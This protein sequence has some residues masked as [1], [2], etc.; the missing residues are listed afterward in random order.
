MLNE[1]ETQSELNPK[2]WDGDE[3]RPKVRAAFLKIAKSFYDFLDVSEFAQVEDVILIGSNANYNWTEHSDIDLHVLINYLHVDAN[4]HIVNNYFHAKKSVWNEH[5]PLIYKGMNIELYAQDSQQ[6]LH[7]SVGVYSV[8]RGKWLKKPDAATVSVDDA[9]IQLKADPYEYE[10]DSLQETDPHIERKI[11]SIKKR[12]KHLRQTGLEAEGEYSVENMAYKH[13][14]NNGYLER[15]T[16]LEKKVKMDTLQV[17]RV[18]NELETPI[19]KENVAGLVDK[20]K[21]QVK[22]FI[23]AT[24]NESEETKLALA[25]I[26]QYINGQQLSAEEWKWIRNQMVDVIKMLGLTTMAIAPGG[27]LV[28]ILAKTLKADKYLL[29][30][31]FK[32][33]EHEKEVTESLIMHVTGRKPL[34]ATDWKQIV[35]KTGGVVDTK[36]QWSHPGRCTMI[37][38]QN[39]A[40]TM[41]NVSHP[42]LG[43]DNTGHMQM[44][45]PEQH[46]QF[47]GK[48]VFEIPQTAQWQTMIMQ[49]Q[50]AAKNGSQYK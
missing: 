38:T 9:A 32:K 23:S 10:I 8:M 26:L 12:L 15:L 36:G 44:M 22:K 37:P 50:N 3:L 47:P 21:H 28:A 7:A 35:H 49:I 30:S 48:L 4:Y 42:V 2:L 45:Q 16:Q 19:A 41:Q 6:K 34:G 25:M 24:K 17:E 13:L 33:P 14:R 43:I 29:P 20:A 1:Y 31:S 18:V 5:Y 27:S 39:G 11:L 40:I 46:Y